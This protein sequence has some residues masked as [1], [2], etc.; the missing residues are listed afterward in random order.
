[1]NK[2]HIYGTLSFRYTCRKVRHSPIN[3]PHSL[4]GPSPLRHHQRP[5]V[6]R[7]RKR[8]TAPSTGHIQ[9]ASSTLSDAIRGQPGSGR[10]HKSLISPNF[11]G[12]I[13]A[14]YKVRLGRYIHTPAV[15]VLWE[16]RTF[17]Q[18]LGTYLCLQNEKSCIY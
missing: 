9:I 5:A 1:M 13:K 6:F 18:Q 15:L 16:E 11:S 10:G 14:G 12:K 4:L 7:E 3:L 17:H 8:T 2:L